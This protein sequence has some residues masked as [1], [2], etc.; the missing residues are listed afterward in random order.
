[1]SIDIRPMFTSRVTADFISIDA[2]IRAYELASLIEASL[3]DL[4]FDADFERAF[5]EVT[6]A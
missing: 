6:H 3:R 4:D 5:E 1:M 2:A